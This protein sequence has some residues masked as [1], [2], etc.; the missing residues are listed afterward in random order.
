MSEEPIITYVEKK[1]ERYILPRDVGPIGR[2]FG[3]R[4]PVV[5]VRF[6]KVEE[7]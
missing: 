2:I 1:P 7:V 4:G 6:D 5:D 3:V